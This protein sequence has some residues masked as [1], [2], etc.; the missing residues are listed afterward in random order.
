MRRGGLTRGRIRHAEQRRI[1]VP[2]VGIHSS[3]RNRDYGR[4]RDKN[5]LGMQHKDLGRTSLVRIYGRISG[6]DLRNDVA[7][8]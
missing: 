5:D 1:S 6:T 3:R 2:G 8:Q 7:L 4:V